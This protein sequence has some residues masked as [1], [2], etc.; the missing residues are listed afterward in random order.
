M[1]RD[2]TFDGQGK[3]RSKRKINLHNQIPTSLENDDKRRYTIATRRLDRVAVE[4]GI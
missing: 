4:C 1:G 2:R 3:W